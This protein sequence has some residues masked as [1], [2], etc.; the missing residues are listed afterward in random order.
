MIKNSISRQAKAKINLDLL[1]CG[2]R[3]DGYHLLDSLVVFADFGDRISVRPDDDLILGISGP[4]A[5]GLAGE[6]DN[7]ILKAARLLR[8]RFDIGCGAKISLVK[9]LP[10]SS[11]IGGGSADAA[12][13]LQ[14]LGE[15]WK[16]RNKTA[17]ISALAR[18]LGADLPVCLISTTMQMRG[19]GEIL[20]PVTLDFPLHLLMVNPAVSVATKDIFAA[21]TRRGAAFS[22]PRNLP[23]I[24]TTLNQLTTILAASGNDL[25][26]DACE[27][28]PEIKTVLDRIALTDQCVFSAMSG[29]GATCFGLFSTKSAACEAARNIFRDFPHWWVQSARVPRVRS[30]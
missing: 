1:L 13:T 17:E 23:D 12:A 4:F 30:Y 22:P 29:S 20:R 27:A 2:R 16:L 3:R 14:A 9:Q 8:D 15:L 18:S 7:I 19:I 26:Y 5:D 10:V 6:K 24:I 11:G 28:V 21:R 25:H